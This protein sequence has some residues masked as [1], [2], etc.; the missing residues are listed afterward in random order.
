LFVHDGS[1]SQPCVSVEFEAFLP[2]LLLPAGASN[3]IGVGSQILRSDGLSFTE[4]LKRHSLRRNKLLEIG[5]SA[6]ARED[7]FISI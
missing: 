4:K 7:T 1:R 2:S 3:A 5:Q 6:M